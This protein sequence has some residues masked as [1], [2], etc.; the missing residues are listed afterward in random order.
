MRV[1]N[2]FSPNEWV[3]V[4]ALR[5]FRESRLSVKVGDEEREVFDTTSR[6]PIL[7]LKTPLYIGGY[8]HDRIRV[9]PHVG[10]E[11]GFHGCVSDVSAF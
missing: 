9:S 3:T 2:F 8:D 4:N 6:N 11:N 1:D 10:V 5:D 7:N